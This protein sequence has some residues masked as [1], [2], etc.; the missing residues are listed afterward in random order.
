MSE[1]AAATK[2]ATINAVVA[3]IHVAAVE[4]SAEFYHHLGFEIGN[5]VPRPLPPECPMQWAWLYQPNAPNWKTAGNLM[6]VRDS[7]SNPL[8][9]NEPHVLFYLYAPDLKGLREELLAKGLKPGEI[10]YPEYLPKGEFRIDDPDGYMLM[11]G[12]SIEGS[13]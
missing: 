10:S 3:M 2:A 5:Y 4:R 6:L 12:Q 11:I 13:P 7:R 1:A 8:D 9:R